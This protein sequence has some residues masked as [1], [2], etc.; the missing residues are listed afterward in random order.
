M[1]DDKLNAR[2]EALESRFL[3]QDAALEEL[4]RSLLNQEQLLKQ[5][6]E[7]IKRLEMQLRT[8][9]PSPVATPEEETP[10]PHY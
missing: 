3:H 1:T 9:T 5:Q 6:T 2:I 10:P 7:T 8:L 4:T